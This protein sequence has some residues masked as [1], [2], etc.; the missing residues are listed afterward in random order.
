LIELH[1]SSKRRAKE[2][3]V[4]CNFLNS[5]AILVPRLVAGGCKASGRAV[6]HVDH[7]YIDTPDNF[8]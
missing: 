1:P 8:T 6:D 5:C 7:T 4:L 2:I 3:A